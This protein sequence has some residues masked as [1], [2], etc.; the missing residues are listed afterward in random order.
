MIDSVNEIAAE[1][2]WPSTWLNEQATSYMPRGTDH[3][4][5]VVFDHPALRVLAASPEHLLA[6]KV[7]AAR[8]MDVEDTLK[9]LEQ[10]G[11]S[12]MDE[13]LE[14]INRVVPR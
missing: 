9:L 14:I 1:R 3:E 7:M 2:G 11:A 8:R 4:S 5:R 12:S 13:A 10:A 6:M